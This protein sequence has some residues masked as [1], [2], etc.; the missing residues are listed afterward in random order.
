MWLLI[1]KGLL[2][3]FT[4]IFL[5]YATISVSEIKKKTNYI[6]IIIIIIVAT[7]NVFA[8]KYSENTLKGIVTLLGFI[9]FSIRRTK[10][11]KEGVV[12]G[13]VVYIY[14]IIGDI[15]SAM[16]VSLSG[17]SDFIVKA[18]NLSI[19]K[20][21]YCCSLG[22][23]MFLVINIKT[24]K[25]FI[26]YC[27]KHLS[28][29]KY[30]LSL[31]LLVGF[32]F[33]TSII[34][35]ITNMTS[36]K[37]NILAYILLVSIGVGVFALI[38]N[39]TKKDELKLIN[40]NLIINN[41]SFMK[42]INNYKLFKHNFKYELNAISLVGDDKVKKLIK[43]YLDEYDVKSSFDNSDL[44]KLPSGIRNLVYRKL[45]ESTDTNCNIVVDNFINYDPFENISIKKMCKLMQCLG[46]ILDNAIEEAMQTKSK[47]IYIKISEDEKNNIIFEC[48]NQIKNNI[49]IDLIGIEKESNKA[50]HMG[51]GTSYLVKQKAFKV[52]NV[53]RNDIYKVSL[54]FSV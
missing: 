33:E 18:S 47:Y 9:A 21:A 26:K 27:I 29:S 12:N 43:L 53:I 5:Y 42:I 48:H 41:E 54:K 50:D 8:N 11:P 32:L 38:Y 49:D 4:Y 51:V 16:L 40:Q 44:M 15:L 31:I 28:K 3:L 17:Y 20:L 39:I 52:T 22:L 13:F 19:V 2:I 6:D 30:V 10:T 45:L 46:I 25:K 1:L 7:C 23:V 36:L 35:S 34:I 14:A 37:Q 24:I